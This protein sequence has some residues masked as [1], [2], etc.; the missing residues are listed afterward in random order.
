MQDVTSTVGDDR[1][2]DT[3]CGPAKFIIN[4][5]FRI[6][7]VV[8]VAK[9]RGADNKGLAKVA[10][11]QGDTSPRAECI[12]NHRAFDQVDPAGSCHLV[13]AVEGFVVAKLDDGV[14]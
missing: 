14:V 5:F 7:Y 1:A 9:K 12:G 3:A 8:F 10:G 2:I 4:A 11:T 13:H 6:A